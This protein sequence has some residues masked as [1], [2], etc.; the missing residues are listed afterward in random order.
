M[1]SFACIVDG[2]A[3]TN[4][5]CVGGRAPTRTSPGVSGG[6]ATDHPWRGLGLGRSYS[7]SRLVISTT[8]MPSCQR[9]DREG[10]SGANAWCAIVR[11][12]GASGGDGWVRRCLSCTGPGQ[13]SGGRNPAFSLRRGCVDQGSRTRGG[14]EWSGVRKGGE[15]SVRS[16]EMVKGEM[17]MVM[18]QRGG[19]GTFD[20][21]AVRRADYIVPRCSGGWRC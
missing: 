5:R 18:E 15:R 21:V 11:G 14:A 10:Q 3:W 9:M 4:R 17:V 2:W 1:V 13:S 12:D 8:G 16:L 6:V 7:S 20:G 19:T